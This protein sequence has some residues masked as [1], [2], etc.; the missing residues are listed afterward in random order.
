MGT[1][2]ERNKRNAIG[3]YTTMVNDQD[4]IKAFD[5]YGGFWYLQHNPEVADD[6]KG[7]LEHFDVINKDIPHQDYAIRALAEDDLVM[8][9][10]WHRE[11]TS[12]FP[13]EHTE[14]NFKKYGLVS[15]DLFRFSEDGKIIEH[16]DAAQW[17]PMPFKWLTIG[18]IAMEP[19][20]PKGAYTHLE[21]PISSHSMLDGETEIRDLDRG[22]ENKEKAREFVEQVL[23]QHKFENFE[24]YFGDHLIQ[25]I[26][27]LSDG[28]AAYKKGIHEFEE[29]LGLKYLMNHRALAEGNF[30]YVHSQGVFRGRT[31]SIGDLF[32][33]ENGKIA[34]VWQ[35]HWEAV[36]EK[37]TAHLNTMF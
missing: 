14:E 8:L 36:P 30:A 26:Q 34:E 19:W 25:H 23:I 31:T 33:F 3:F 9:H 6:R 12:N 17:P 20:W 27:H 24:S 16:W 2:Q 1:K 5:L 22:Q 29:K 10:I 21:E 28:V 18:V 4:P 11:L 32:R 37:V 13:L 15:M 35:C 7:F